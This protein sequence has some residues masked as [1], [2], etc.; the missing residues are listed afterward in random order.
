MLFLVGKDA[1]LRTYLFQ[2]CDGFWLAGCLPA[3]LVETNLSDLLHQLGE[4]AS[5]R[6]K[7]PSK[8]W[9]RASGRRPQTFTSPCIA[10]P[11]KL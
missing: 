2:S 3:A 7:C 10:L 11:K 9:W 1:R 8:S 6:G 4:V 5:G